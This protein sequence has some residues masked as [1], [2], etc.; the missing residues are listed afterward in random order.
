MLLAGDFNYPCLNWETL[1]S[2]A[3]DDHPTHL[4]MAKLADLFLVQHIS[5]PTRYR[6]GS[7]PSLLDLVITTEEGMVSNIE[8]LPGLSRSDHLQIRFTVHCYTAPSTVQLT[9]KPALH[10]AD[11]NLLRGEAGKVDWGQ[12]RDMNPQCAYTFFEKSLLGLVDQHVPKTRLGKS[13]NLYMNKEALK[14]RKKK[15]NLWA[16]YSRTLDTNDLEKFNVCRNKLRKM[17]R[18]L[19]RDF[20]ALLTSNIKTNPKAFWKYANTRLKTK[21]GIDVL[22]DELGQPKSSP[23]DKSKLLNEFFSSVFTTEDQTT[24][25]A[26]Q[27]RHLPVGR[28]S[29]VVITSE[30]VHQKLLKLNVSGAPGPDGLH[31]RVLKE[32][33]P[34]I[35]APLSWLFNACLETSS[36][37]NEWRHAVV[38]PIFK[39]GSRQSASNYR[40]ISLTSTVCKTMEAIMR[41]KILNH[42]ATNNLLSP[43]QHGFCPSRSCSTQLLETM[44]AWTKTI[45]DKQP[46][47]AVYLDFRKAF[48]SV[49]HGRLLLKLQEHGIDGKPLGWMRAFLTNRTQQVLVEGV[50]ST[51]AAVTSGVPQGSVLGPLLFLLYINDLPDHISSSIKL[52]ADD[53]KVYNPVYSSQARDALQEDLN[54]L[55]NWSSQWLLPFNLD[56]CHVLH[57]GPSNPNATYMMQGR[58]LKATESERDLGIIVDGLLDF[59]QQTTGAVAKANRILGVIKKS[60]ANL[61]KQSL[62]VLFISLIRPLLEFSNCIWGPFSRG[63]QRLVE[64]VQRRATKMVPELRQKPYSERLRLLDLPS[65]TY[66]RLR[67]D[68]I[69]IY[70]IL[71]DAMHVQDGLLRLAEAGITRGHPFKLHKPHAFSRARRNFLSIRAVNN[72]NNLPCHV[73]S[74]PSLNAFKSRLDIH[75]K[76]IRF[77]SV[78][79]N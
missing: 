26:P 20:E 59:H 45:E 35:A 8:Y 19:R 47:D 1:S 73:V 17:T 71:H 12:I 72:W 54:K 53:C 13:K 67:G 68:M 57:V 64:R 7:Q 76:A 63:D 74:A 5:S 33:A 23:S 69:V 52:F 30:E 3:P 70:Q 25:P 55:G 61:D 2:P 38:V 27:H 51:R 62:P 18:K 50:V 36:V 49:P 10:R 29:D 43:H 60:F 28:L 34:Q 56:K 24:M 14:L 41:D 78:F 40:P 22:K 65:L 15:R 79:D 75:W 16:T 21:P 9:K 46:L 66:R 4:F 77:S 32:L 31:P 42:L 6:A 39:K 44:D 37:P 11:F 58:P 48:D